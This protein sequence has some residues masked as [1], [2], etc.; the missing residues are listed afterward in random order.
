[1]ARVQQAT[2]QPLQRPGH[3]DHQCDLMLATG[4]FVGWGRGEG[5]VE[6]EFLEACEDM[7]ALGEEEE[8]EEEY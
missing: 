4:D 7:A 1:M 2:P 6:G 5:M 3:L 8:E